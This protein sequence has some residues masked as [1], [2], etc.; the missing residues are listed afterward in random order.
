MKQVAIGRV[1]KN[2]NNPRTIDQAKLKALVGSVQDF[3]EMMKLRPIIVNKDMMVLGGNMRLE[4]ARQLG[5]DKVWIQVADLTPE[6][7]KEFIVKDNISYG[8][9]DYDQLIGEWETDLLLTWGLEI[10]DSDYFQV[11]DSNEFKAPR[12]SDDDYAAFEL[13]MLKHNKYKLIDSLNNAKE[14]SGAGSQEDALMHIIE[15]YENRK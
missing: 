7:E 6:Q 8:V 9:W 1:K 5:M 4:A 11:D 2:P 10:G 3:P 13:V 14:E 12:P 15:V